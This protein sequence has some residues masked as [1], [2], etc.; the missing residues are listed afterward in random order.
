[1]LNK[2]QIIN[3]MKPSSS[4]TNFRKYHLADTKK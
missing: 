1:M 2:K 4:L 3:E